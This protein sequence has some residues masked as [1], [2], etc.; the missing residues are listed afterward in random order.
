MS[1]LIFLADGTSCVTGEIAKRSLCFWSFEVR[2]D[3]DSVLG[4][5][6]A[7]RPLIYPWC[8]SPPFAVFSCMIDGKQERM[9]RRSTSTYLR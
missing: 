9:E 4:G 3:E 8:Q 7:S 2:P 6:W 1:L 5:L